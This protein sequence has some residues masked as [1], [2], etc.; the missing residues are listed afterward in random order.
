MVYIKCRNNNKPFFLLNDM[1]N[2][3][4]KQTI[5]KGERREDEYD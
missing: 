2:N 5:K 3:G 4:W 1:I